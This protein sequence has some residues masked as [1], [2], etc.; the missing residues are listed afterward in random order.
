[1]A[2]LVTS[3]S[4]P[5][6]PLVV[7]PKRTYKQDGSLWFSPFRGLTLVLLPFFPAGPS[8]T[9]PTDFPHQQAH[10]C[11]SSTPSTQPAR[12]CLPTSTS[13]AHRCCETS[14]RTARSRNRRPEGTQ[15]KRLHR[16]SSSTRSSTRSRTG[17][18]PGPSR[19]YSRWKDR[20]L[21]Q[22]QQHPPPLPLRHHRTLPLQRLRIHSPQGGP[23]PRL[24]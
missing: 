7:G 19:G 18:P 13:C 4:Q 14:Q 2:R 22:Q 16:S 3:T 23:P 17:Q 12:C 6:M 1:M 15:L 24:P 8:F 20:C 11:H 5:A 10:R 21:Q 9:L